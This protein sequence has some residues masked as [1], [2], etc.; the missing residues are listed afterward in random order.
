MRKFTTQL[1][2]VNTLALSLDLSDSPY[3]HC[4]LARHFTTNIRFLL[5]NQTLHVPHQKFLLPAVPP[6]LYQE[7][8][9]VEESPTTPQTS[10]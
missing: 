2:I 7:G 4:R 1:L 5:F 8:G 9:T 10:I 3:P 6:R